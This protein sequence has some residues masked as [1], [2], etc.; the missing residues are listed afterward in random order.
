MPETSVAYY[1]HY[2]VSPEDVIAHVVHIQTSTANISEVITQVQTDMATATAAVEGQLEGPL[3]DAPVMVITMG[4]EV[5]AT[6]RHCC[7]CL[8]YFAQ[9]IIDYDL[10]IDGLNQQILAALEAG[11]TPNP[12]SAVVRRKG[13][14]DVTLDD[15]ATLV[16]QMLGRG[17]NAQDAAFL[18]QEGAIVS[19]PLGS[20][21]ATPGSG[22]VLCRQASPEEAAAYW[23]ALSPAERAA[24]IQQHP[25]VIGATDGLPAGARDEANRIL[26]QRDLALPDGDPR[27]ENAETVSASL[28][29]IETERVDPHTDQPVEAQLLIYDP[30][31]DSGDGRAAIV[32]GDADTADNVAF[33]VPGI[34][35]QVST[36]PDQTGDGWNVYR[37]AREG[38][39]PDETTAVVVWS[40]Y[41]E[42]DDQWAEA[43]ATRDRADDGGALLAASYNGLMVSRTD[44]PYTTVI[45][46]SYGSTVVSYAVTKYDIHPDNV[47]FIGSP[48]AGQDADADTGGDPGGRPGGGAGGDADRAGVDG[49]SHHSHGDSDVNADG[50][51][52]RYPDG[53]PHRDTDTSVTAGRP[54]NWTPTPRRSSRRSLPAKTMHSSAVSE[55]PRRPRPGVALHRPRLARHAVVDPLQQR[56]HPMVAARVRRHPRRTTPGVACRRGQRRG[57]PGQDAP[58][59]RRVPVGPLHLDLVRHRLGAAVRRLDVLP[60]PAHARHRPG[61][62]E[63]GGHAVGRGRPRPEVG[64]P[65]PAGARRQTTRLR[66]G[67]ATPS[68]QRRAHTRLRGIRAVPGCGYAE[69]ARLDGLTCPRAAF[70]CSERRC[71]PAARSL[72]TRSNAAPSGQRLL[73]EPA[74]PE[75]AQDAHEDDAASIGDSSALSRR[76]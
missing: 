67:C 51:S 62:L 68:G 61:H 49:S 74:Q 44:D 32:I 17:P 38:A 55:P 59:R 70:D 23:A 52:V 14:L 53:H 18:E 72:R 26:L 45:G 66:C 24:V 13:R 12:D 76:S 47:V 40:G 54:T 3:A 33:V 2:P 73:V 75:S 29:Q 8:L 30:E 41:D 22:A 15:E 58:V 28:T 50:D 48:G 11:T 35:N 46:H 63:E 57:A 34:T 9:A 16:A 6:V 21:H 27:R 1:E 5:E 42:P 65:D 7:G 69:R 60:D 36:M 4:A 19:D 43:T 39:A 25:D 71:S 56:G 64:R 31:A 10:G 37:E 20:A